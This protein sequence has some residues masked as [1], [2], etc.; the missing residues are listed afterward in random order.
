MENTGR[1]ISNAGDFVRRDEKAYNCEEGRLV[2]CSMTKT[3]KILQGRIKR[4]LEYVALWQFLCF[5]LLVCFVWAAQIV[6]LKRFIFSTAPAT[7]DWLQTCLLTAGIIAVGII[8]VGYTY[9]QEKRILRG[10]I[11]VC[12][13]CHKVQIENK[14]WQQMEAY[15][16]DHTRA[17]FTHGVCPTCYERIMHDLEKP[18]D[19][20]SS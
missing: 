12:S 14:A 15:V 11:I 20:K 7:A 10:F 13:Y 3:P 6:D 9:I 8:T 17:E 4:P 2:F 19:T 5:F 16:S 1:D 18:G